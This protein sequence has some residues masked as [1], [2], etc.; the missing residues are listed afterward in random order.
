M[1]DCRKQRRKGAFGIFAKSDSVLSDT[2]GMFVDHTNV[3][4][5]G[6]EILRLSNH[7]R[8]IFTMENVKICMASRRNLLICRE[9][10]DVPTMLVTEDCTPFDND[11]L[12]SANL[13]DLA[14]AYKPP[15]L[16]RVRVRQ[17]E[18]QAVAHVTCIGV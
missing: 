1:G 11:A 4:H 5:F 14:R 12:V 9:P 2:I 13:T 8:D 6:S 15:G 7:L 17:Y 10:A 16:S 3:D 18:A